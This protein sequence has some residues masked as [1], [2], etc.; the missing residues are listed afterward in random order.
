MFYGYYSFYNAGKRRPGTVH[1]NY[2]DG[3]GQDDKTC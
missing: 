2:F 3:S 1:T